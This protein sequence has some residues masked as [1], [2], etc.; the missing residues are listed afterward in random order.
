MTARL[1]FIR[2]LGSAAISPF[3]LLGFLTPGFIPSADLEEAA[4]STGSYTLARQRMLAAF[5]GRCRQSSLSEDSF[6]D[7]LILYSWENDAGLLG[8]TTIA[9]RPESGCQVS[10]KALL[11]EPFRAEIGGKPMRRHFTG[12]RR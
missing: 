4:K 9:C 12:C 2:M 10:A 8:T 7:E 11:P 3:L 1:F 5:V 6:D